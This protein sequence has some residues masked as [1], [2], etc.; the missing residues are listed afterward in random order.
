MNPFLAGIYIVGFNFAPKGY[1]LCDG[2]TLAI[3]TN[4]ALFS[5]LGTT[6]GGNGTSTF[7]L[8]DLQGRVPI[9]MG[10]GAGLSAYV[11]GQQSGVE[12]VTLTG[13]QMPQHNH[14]LNANSLTGNTAAVNGSY[15]AGG[16]STGSGPN[17][18]QIKT[19]TTTAPDGSA[20][21]AA[22]V[23][24]T[25]SSQPHTNIQPYLTL[26]FVIALQGIFPSRN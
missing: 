16:P 5:L 3:S 7:Q 22:T 13:A 15:L 25:G 12:T 24:F 23:S 26:N 18:S 14:S 9:H 8:P 1:A 20:L 21:N 11:I 2:Q 10:N 19:Y 6:Y 17:A 4:T